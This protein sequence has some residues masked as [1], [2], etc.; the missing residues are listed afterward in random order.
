MERYSAFYRRTFVCAAAVILGYV[1]LRMVR[2]FWGALLWAAMLAFVLY[3]LQVRL[4]RKLAGRAGLAA[5]TLT[6]LTPFVIV[7]PLSLIAIAF[8]GQVSHLVTYLRGSAIAPVPSMIDRIEHYPLIGP[9]VTWVRDNVP[10]TSDQIQGWVT[11]SARTLLQSAAAL[12]GDLVL[13]VAGTLLDFFLMLFLLFFLLRDGRTMLTH[14]MRLVPL[15]DRQRE[16]LMQHVSDVLRAVIFGTVMTALIQGTF[17]GIGFALVRL[18][19]PV[20][21]GVL[22]AAAAFI[23]A[24]GT[25]AVMIPAILYLAFSGRWGAAVFFALWSAGVIAAEYLLRP[26]LASRHAAVSALTVF[27]G[28]LGGVATFGLVGILLGPVLLSLIVAL[29]QLAEAAVTKQP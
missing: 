27:V 2:P 20:V 19:S 11:D 1:F 29:V 8:A 3:P 25:G 6:C 12:S 21:F 23:P 28:A 14:L 10:V 15:E 7:A 17:I 13:G 5:A 16:V 4:R 18:P 9:A 26:V 22:G 24:V